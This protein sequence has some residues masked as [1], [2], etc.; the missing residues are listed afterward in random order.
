MSRDHF[1]QKVIFASFEWF[2]DAWRVTQEK[3]KTFWKV[4]KDKKHLF[5]LTEFFLS[6]P[7]NHLVTPRN[8]SGTLWG[9]LTPRLG[10]LVQ[11][12]GEI[13]VM[14]A[15]QTFDPFSTV[16]SGGLWFNW[17]FWKWVEKWTIEWHSVAS[18]PQFCQTGT[19]APPKSAGTHCALACWKNIPWRGRQRGRV[20][21]VRNATDFLFRVRYAV[22]VRVSPANFGV[23]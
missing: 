10:A 3:G 21:D 17:I 12:T 1:N 4:S 8:Y 6:Y 11:E 7:F 13:F 23:F 14:P 9:N 18:G 22:C 19:K 5:I 16:R 15:S 2:I 20:I